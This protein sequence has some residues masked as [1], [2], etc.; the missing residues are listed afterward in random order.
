MNIFKRVRQLQG[1]V[2]L[3]GATLDEYGVENASLKK[4]LHKI[5]NHEEWRYEGGCS[6]FGIRYSK[7]CTCCGYRYGMEYDEWAEEKAIVELSKA[8]EELTKAKRDV[9]RFE[10]IK[11]VENKHCATKKD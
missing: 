1:Q 6:I 4:K 2:N 11:N 9:E 8:K 5:C 10:K 3:I 7:E